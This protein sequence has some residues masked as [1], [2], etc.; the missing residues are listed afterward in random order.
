MIN[1]VSPPGVLPYVKV[2]DVRWKIW[3]KPVK[4]TNLVWHQLYL[5]PKG[6][7]L[8]QNRLN[9]QPM[10]RKLACASKPDSKGQ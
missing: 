6:Y 4:E 7:H 5:T 8:K 3:K 9:Y 2:G 10:F 1:A